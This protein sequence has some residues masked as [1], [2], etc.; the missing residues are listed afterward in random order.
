M[1]KKEVQK[2]LELIEKAKESKEFRAWLKKNEDGVLA[3]DYDQYQGSCAESFETAE[4][5]ETWALSIWAHGE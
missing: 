4:D 3:F 2:A 5:F 1:D